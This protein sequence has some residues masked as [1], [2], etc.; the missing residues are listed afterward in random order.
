MAHKRAA[1][2]VLPTVIV[3]ALWMASPALSQ[4]YPITQPNPPTTT[5]VQPAAPAAGPVVVAPRPGPQ[6]KVAGVA[7]NQAPAEPASEGL[8]FTGLA[9]PGFVAAAVWLFA[10]SANL[11][12]AARRRT[13]RA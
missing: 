2:L 8:A 4:P 10:L 11:V 9:T 13:A 7:A 5:V 6:A 3:I 12:V 1:L